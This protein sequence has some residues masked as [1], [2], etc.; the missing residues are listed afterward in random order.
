MKRLPCCFSMAGR[1]WTTLVC[2]LVAGAGC[3]TE[4]SPRAQGH[5]LFFLEAPESEHYRAMEAQLPVAGTTI[6]VLPTPVLV[7]E[8]FRNVELVQVELG[9]CLLFQ[10]K[11][12][13]ALSLYQISQDYQGYRLVL[14]V[15]GVP[16]GVRMIDSA[17]GDGNLF[18]F[19]EY[20]DEELAEVVAELRY[21]L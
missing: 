1:I 11:P 16:R 8:D 12:Q 19:T 15:G 3:Q 18:T 7:K 10:V 14:V 21:D 13:A 17:L 9:K 20:T 6:K 2:L 4:V 5:F